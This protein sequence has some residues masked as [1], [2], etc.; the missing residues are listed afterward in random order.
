M[1]TSKTRKRFSWNLVRRA[2]GEVVNVQKKYWTNLGHRDIIEQQETF[3]YKEIFKYK[4]IEN[5]RKLK[6]I[7]KDTTSSLQLLL[8]FNI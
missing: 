3:A 2:F 8:S 5:K 1:R 4:K 7:N 6:D